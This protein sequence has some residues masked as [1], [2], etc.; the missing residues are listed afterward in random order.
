MIRFVKHQNIDPAKWDNAVRHALF[1]T[2]FAS[3]NFLDVI[4]G[5]AHWNALIEDDY[6]GV[7]PLPYRSK[8][9]IPYV[10]TPFFLPQMGIFSA[11]PTDENRIFSFLKAIPEQY[12]Q[13]DLL[14]NKENHPV[15]PPENQLLFISHQL[16]LNKSYET[17]NS[18]YSENTRRNIKSAEK[19]Q[20]SFEI[21]GNLIREIIQLFQSNRGKEAAVH[22]TEKDYRHL[23]KA[24]DL[25]LKKELL[26]VLGVRDSSQHLVAGAFIVRDAQRAWF[27]F[28]GRD[29]N[30][31]ECK[32][33]FFLL[34][35]YIKLHC[36]IPLILDFNGS[37]ND[38]VAR[39]YRG[40]GG[41]P[42]SISMFQRSLF[43][44]NWLRKLSLLSKR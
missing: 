9:G 23:Q 5:D 17:I 29:A 32:P 38:N 10:Y 39:L 16:D 35:E 43:P 28:S 12:R 13:V 34:N 20:L 36:N 2:V 25:L 3:Y 6:L 40:F 26:D 4:S 24:A 33:M 11:D 41:V 8:C 1:S 14:L 7:M 21:N 31:S 42:Y 44:A 37:N 22:F 18:D 27:W 19:H 30:V 15:L